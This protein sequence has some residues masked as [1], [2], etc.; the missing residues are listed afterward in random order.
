MDLS[1]VLA[2]KSLFFA[3]RA[4]GTAN[5]LE[6]GQKYTALANGTRCAITTS[7]ALVPLF[8]V[9]ECLARTS[10]N[11]TIANAAQK[12]SSGG[13]KEIAMAISGESTQKALT[14]MTGIVKFL[15]KLGIVGNIS[16]AVAKCLD[17]DDI[18]KSEVFMQAAGNCAGMYLFENLYS[19]AVKSIKPN[20][21]SDT[22]SKLSKVFKNK[23]PILKSIN[24]GSV[25]LG[26]GFVTASLFGCKI[27]ELFGQSIFDNSKAAEVKKMKLAKLNALNVKQVN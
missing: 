16:Y 11:P 2:Y 1:A 20:E 17:A 25:L 6:E 10:T 27:G 4:K 13:L 3:T 26:I 24:P 21:I 9:S 23:I 7:Q 14:G 19:K 8:A 12:I 5:Q 15:S 18:D 22:T